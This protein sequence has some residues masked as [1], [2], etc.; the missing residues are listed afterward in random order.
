MAALEE[1]DRARGLEE[2]GRAFRAHV[3]HSFA[4]A[5]R[6]WGHAW[7]GGLFARAPAAGKT[8]RYYPRLSPYA[9]AFSLSLDMALLTFG[10]ALKRQEM[11]SPRL[12]AIFSQPYLLS[13]LLKRR[14]A[15]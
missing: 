4:N 8:R 15:E 12:C 11:V 13:P 1:S 5:L 10:G 14:D 3:G 7:T 9:A 2:F 6:A